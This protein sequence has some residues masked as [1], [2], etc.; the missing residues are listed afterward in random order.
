MQI[1]MY[2]FI[3]LHIFESICIKLVTNH[4]SYECL[5]RWLSFSTH[6][7]PPSDH[8][9]SKPPKESLPKQPSF[10]LYQVIYDHRKRG[11]LG[12]R[13]DDL[14]SLYGLNAGLKGVHYVQLGHG[15]EMFEMPGEY[16]GKYMTWAWVKS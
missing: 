7:P 3:Y 12:F 13:P 9:C 4:G 14:F 6:T 8:T 15:Y 1:Y 16:N 10:D 2:I 5:R 11:K